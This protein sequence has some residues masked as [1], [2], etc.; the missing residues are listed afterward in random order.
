[1]PSLYQIK[2]A[3]KKISLATG[4]YRPAR[5]LND[6]FSRRRFVASFRNDIE[7]YKK[8]LPANSFCFDVGANIGE[9]T[10]ALLRAG[11]RV[12]AIEPQP[13]CVAE[14]RA[15]CGV[16]R[17]LQIRQ[18]AIASEI[19]EAKLYIS[20]IYHASS[21]L[22]PDWTP[23]HES[24]S[25]PV[26]TL[27]SL[28]DEYGIPYY[29]KID[30]EGSELEVLKGLSRPIRLVSLEFHQ[31]ESDIKKTFE[32]L[33]R[34]RALASN[35]SINLTPAENNH[36]YFEEWLSFADFASRFPSEFL[37]REGYYYGDLW[38]ESN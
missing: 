31:T 17:E 10:D 3:V 26:V 30:V 9:K 28:M 8:L 33:S 29:C 25:V 13:T 1:M 37:D 35:I 18:T 15:R 22:N 19:G 2:T 24:I 32:C 36:F 4:T 11:M 7:F 14:I 6:L 5:Y 20:D 38:I 21:S 12:L 23:S 34:L 16:P 27:D